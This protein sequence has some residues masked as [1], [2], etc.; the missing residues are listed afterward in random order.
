MTGNI[1]F[2]QKGI[3]VC[4]NGNNTRNDIEFTRMEIKEA[5]APEELVEVVRRQERALAEAIG[6]E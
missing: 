1:A 6:S 4:R 5:N 2:L 3:K